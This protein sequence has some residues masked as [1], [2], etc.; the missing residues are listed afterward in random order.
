M[1][2][3]LAP[4]IKRPK[5]TLHRIAQVYQTTHYIIAG[6]HLPYLAGNVH[7][8]LLFIYILSKEVLVS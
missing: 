2:G 4:N 7:G 8:F 5:C 3:P 1:I 6:T